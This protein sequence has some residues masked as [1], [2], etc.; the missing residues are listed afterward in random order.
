[1]LAMLNHGFIRE[2]ATLVILGPV[3]LHLDLAA[4]GALCCFRQAPDDAH[5]CR[6]DGVPEVF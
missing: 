2:R 6:E 4:W 5:R 3:S 1:M